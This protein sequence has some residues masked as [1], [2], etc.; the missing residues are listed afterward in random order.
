[1]AK[2]SEWSGD[3]FAGLWL[4]EDANQKLID[5][6]NN[7]KSIYIF[8]AGK[9]GNGLKNYLGQC[10]VPLKGFVTSDTF[11]EFKQV[12]KKGETGLVI[13][14]SDKFLNE[15]M[16][17]IN[18]VVSESDLF[19][20]SSEYR[21]K[22]GQFCVENVRD[23]C[24]IAVYLVSHCN[25]ACKGCR[26]FCPVNRRDFYEYEKC[27]KDIEQI[28]K[29][30]LPLHH[31]NFTGGEPFLHPHLF[32]ILKTTRR[33]FPNVKMQI[34]TNGTLLNRLRDEQ[35]K[36]LIE[37]DIITV[38]TEYPTVINAAKT[39][40]SKADEMG[41]KYSIIYY[42]ETKKFTDEKMNAGRT[43]PKHEFYNCY[44]YKHSTNFLLYKGR[45]F[46][47]GHPMFISYFNEYFN[48]NYEV[49]NGDFVDIYNT[50]AEELYKFKI[51]RKPFCD[52]HPCTGRS[53]MEWGM[54][55]RKIEEWVHIE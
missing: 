29:L 2:V 53:V 46:G 20:T 21:E 35:L 14:L 9:I 11:H 52:Y 25:L 10:D 42:D 13:G 3:Y 6:C 4:L 37:F 26:L 18:S 45:I 48:A 24:N 7:H 43:T 16:P 5:F 51:T 19:M 38:V 54:S 41:I 50:T 17:M 34:F 33:L 28:K 1:M 44:C 36:E 40:Y 30:N 22:I 23:N 12:Y 47:C 49:R 39:F 32:D 15:V 8:G 27:V 31:F 55:E